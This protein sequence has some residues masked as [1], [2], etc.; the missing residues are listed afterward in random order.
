MIVRRFQNLATANVHQDPK[1]QKTPYLQ[2]QEL[3]NLVYFSR[4]ELAPAQS[5]PEHVHKDM[6]EVFYI[7]HGISTFYINGESLIAKQ[8]DCVVVEAGERHRLE[9]PGIEKLALVYFGLLTT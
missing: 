5:V 6:N 4:A 1:I 3:G 7:E 8:S 9:N 2:P